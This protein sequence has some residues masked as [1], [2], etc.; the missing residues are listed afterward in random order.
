MKGTGI[1]LLALSLFFAAALNGQNWSA[2]LI[3]SDSS[4]DSFSSHVAL[5]GSGKTVAVWISN[6]SVRTAQMSFKGSWSS[7]EALRSALYEICTDPHVKINALG[8]IL[9]VWGGG[10]VVPPYAA[11]FSS[12]SLFGKP[13]TFPVSVYMGELDI[14]ADAAFNGS[15]EA[16]AVVGNNVAPL[17]LKASKGSLGGAWGERAFLSAEGHLAF[18]AKVAMND[19]GRIAIVWVQ[20]DGLPQM[21]Y[22]MLS[23]YGGRWPTMWPLY[24]TPL[25]ASGQAAERPQVAMNDNDQTVIVWSR[26]DGVNKIV[27]SVEL[28]VGERWSAPV[29]L[30][31]AGQD[32]ETPQIALNASGKAAAVWSRSNGVNRIIQ[33]ATKSYGENWSA[34]LDLSAA[35]KDAIS[36]KV[37]LND[38]GQA[39]A[40]WQRFDGVDW[41]VQAAT[42]NLG[43]AWSSPANLSEAG[44]NGTDAQIAVNQKGEAAAT[45]SC[46]DGVHSLIKAATTELLPLPPLSLTGYQEGVLVSG[47]I[48][49]QNCLSWSLSPTSNVTAYRIYKE[50]VLQGVLEGNQTAYVDSGQTQGATVAYGV[51]A[52]SSGGGESSI[53]NVTIN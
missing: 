36:P 52:V 44:H 18:Q 24:G 19:R 37:A 10:F 31:L 20:K 6:Q 3:I 47:R 35:G 8:Q 5:N 11:I 12:S 13:W 38:A 22:G 16:V 51:S 1:V 26:S 43:G 28:E 39:A 45:W 17:E 50:G 40:V 4:E 33:A 15:G 25:S 30:S 2:P 21:I 27:Q 7:P 48:D 41:V 29:S 9:A 46:Q 14:D 49:F 32:A 42:F 23:F 34:P 53:V